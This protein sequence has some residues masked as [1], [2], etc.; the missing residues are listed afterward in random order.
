VIN[1]ITRTK[2]NAKKGEEIEVGIT[3][4]CVVYDRDVYYV[5]RDLPRA[6]FISLAIITAEFTLTNLA[7]YIVLDKQS[8]LQSS[9]V[10]MV[11]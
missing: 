7:Y 10:A 4:H 3:V 6:V 1:L 9:T 11:T 8:I 5:S 2:E